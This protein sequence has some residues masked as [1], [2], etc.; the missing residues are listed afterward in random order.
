MCHIILHYK[1]I[2]Q[3]SHAKCFLIQINL[4]YDNMELLLHNKEEVNV[5]SFP[6]KTTD[7]KSAIYNNHS[8]SMSVCRLS[9]LL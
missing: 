6:K 7:F 8:Y 4:C 2:S 1:F 3:K 9:L 5:E